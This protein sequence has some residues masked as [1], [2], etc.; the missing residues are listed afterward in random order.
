VLCRLLLSHLALALQIQAQLPQFGGGQLQGAPFVFSLVL[1]LV[2]LV[3]QLGGEL[4][5]RDGVRLILL[6][7]RALERGQR[8]RHL[9]LP[10]GVSG[11]RRFGSSGPRRQLGRLAFHRSQPALVIAQVRADE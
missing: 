11:K 4:R 9:R 6:V 10:V 3:C 5:D 2:V 7:A 8:V 1:P